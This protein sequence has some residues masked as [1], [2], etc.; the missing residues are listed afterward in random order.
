MLKTLVFN[1]W[2]AGD[3]PWD[4]CTF[5]HDWVFNYVEQLDGLPERIIADSDEVLLVGFSMG[6]S[7]ALR[8]LLRF[9]EK[10]KGL[11]LI[12]ATPCMMEKKESE[13]EVWKGMSERRLA[14][15]KLGTEM[16]FNGD[17]SPM[18]D[19]VNMNRGLDYLRATDLRHE[20]LAYGRARVPSRA[21]EAGRARVP[22]RAGEAG[23]AR[24]PSRA[25]EGLPGRAA[26]PVAI[27]QSE[28]DGI[29]RPA[30]AEFLKR[31]FPQASVTYVPGNEHVLPVT[32]PEL[33]D[34][35]VEEI[36]GIIE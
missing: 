5:E 1:G 12:S 36:I 18:Y 34:K 16:M 10:V 32:I 29:V 21:G 3:E 11:V 13:G 19:P 30:N 24:V 31:V 22:S 35:A 26:I 33:I 20:L 27:F 2:A 7:T 14:A 9:P 17:P 28:R 6:G 25:A 4:L 15:L 8:M 23:R